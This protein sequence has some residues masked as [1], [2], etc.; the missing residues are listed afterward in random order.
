MNAYNFIHFLGFI[1]SQSIK[2]IYSLRPQN[3]IHYF[4]K[5]H[6]NTNK[7]KPTT[8]NPT[9]HDEVCL[10]SDSCSPPALHP[11][12]ERIVSEVMEGGSR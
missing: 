8:T 2:T 3:E 12:A 5:K 9:G 4:M 7:T 11:Q 1:N 6:N 10:R